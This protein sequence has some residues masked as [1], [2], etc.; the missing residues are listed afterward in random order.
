M[1]SVQV[2]KL[3]LSN[4]DLRRGLRV[5]RYVKVV[6]YFPITWGKPCHDVAINSV[7]VVADGVRLVVDGILLMFR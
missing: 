5:P 7:R 3:L 2:T 6:E 4:G 1:A